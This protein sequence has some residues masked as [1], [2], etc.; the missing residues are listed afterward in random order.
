MP[1]ILLI[2]PLFFDASKETPFASQFSSFNRYNMKA[3]V[4]PRV[5]QISQKTLH[6]RFGGARYHFSRGD[7]A[8][9]HCRN[10]WRYENESDS[11]HSWHAARMRAWTESQ[12]VGKL[13]RFDS[14][15][16]YTGGVCQ[17][18]CELPSRDFH[19]KCQCLYYC[20]TVMIFMKESGKKRG[21]RNWNV[22][23]V[24]IS[25][26]TNDDCDVQN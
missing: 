22:W 3:C 10:R 16:F 19:R 5:P 2:Q 7:A 11:L 20:L 8:H 26:Y 1:Y 4:A 9:L 15:H 18:A 12:F 25:K 6:N 14:Q 23:Q 21:N 13:F 24:L 17:L